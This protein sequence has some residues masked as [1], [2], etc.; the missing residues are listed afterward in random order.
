MDEL[1]LT[2]GAVE[3][4]AGV[5]TQAGVGVAH[6]QS[7]EQHEQTHA[8]KHHQHPGEREAV[9]APG[10][11]GQ[12]AQGGDARPGLSRAER[13]RGHA[14]TAFE[15]SL[16]DESGPGSALASGERR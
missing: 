8:T 14:V 6:G 15:V 16:L 2:A 3:S 10:H 12:A 7:V 11:P 4:A 1:A 9:L 13:C 5:Q